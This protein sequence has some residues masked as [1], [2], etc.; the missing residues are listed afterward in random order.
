[1]LGNDDDGTNAAQL[2]RL[3]FPGPLNYYRVKC[4]KIRISVCVRERERERGTVT[5]HGLLLSV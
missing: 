4:K 3:K 1:M 5:L 2:H